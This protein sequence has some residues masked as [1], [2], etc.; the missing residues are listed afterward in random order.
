MIDFSVVLQNYLAKSYWMGRGEE[1]LMLE[2]GYSGSAIKK[3]KKGKYKRIDCVHPR[4]NFH[5]LWCY[6]LVKLVFINSA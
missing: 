1:L 4:F 2:P 3:K 6:I 5:L